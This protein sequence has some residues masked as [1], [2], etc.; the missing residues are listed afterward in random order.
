MEDI[1][2]Q[3]LK[4][5]YEEISSRNKGS[6]FFKFKPG[7]NS[8]RVVYNPKEMTENDL[9]FLSVYV[10][11]NLGP[12]GKSRVVCPKMAG[13]GPCPVC[14]YY[15]ELNSRTD[16]ISVKRAKEIKAREQV[17]YNIIDKNDPKNP[18]FRI[19]NSGPKLLEDILNITLNPKYGN[20]FH[21]ERGRDLT[22]K[23]TE[24]TKTKSGF[25]EYNV[26]ADPDRT[27]VDMDLSSLPDLHVFAKP[28]SIE[29]IE[30]LLGGMSYEEPEE[31]ALEVKSESPRAAAVEVADDDI[32]EVMA[33]IRKRKKVA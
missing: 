1:L 11:R 27:A 4:R 26:M 28:D 32:E 8:V 3:K 31:E 14:S 24:Q 19:M 7:E 6:D 9:P 12:E 10:H 30:S 18:I 23:F 25:N 22:I 13:A 2:L 33:E 29:K 15:E 16:T 21:L 5:K 17:F 20:I